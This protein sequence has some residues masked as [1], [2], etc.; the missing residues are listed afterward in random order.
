M[1]SVSVSGTK[2]RP[3]GQV[4]DTLTAGHCM[5]WIFSTLA[6]P[7]HN[8]KSARRAAGVSVRI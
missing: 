6:Q 4:P 3:S 2:S 7:L 8:T 5:C 1:W